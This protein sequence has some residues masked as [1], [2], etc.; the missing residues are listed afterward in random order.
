M[1]IV[2][3]YIRIRRLYALR[4]RITGIWIGL[5]AIQTDQL[6]L[7]TVEIEPI[8]RCQ[9]STEAGLQRDGILNVRPADTGAQ[10]AIVIIFCYTL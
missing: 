10:S 4:Q 9:N 6:Q 2:P 8:R 1:Q 3:Q 7:F 5:V